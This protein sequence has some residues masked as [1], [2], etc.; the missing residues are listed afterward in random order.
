MCGF[1]VSNKPGV[2]REGLIRQRH[3]GP[4]AVS[5]WKGQGLEMGHVL[6][7]INGSKTIQP[8]VTKKGNVL[9][10]NGE[11]YNCP[12]ENDTAWLGEGMDRYGIRFLEYNNW[13]GAV[14]YLDREKNELL[15]TR[16][17]F[18]A[19][20]LWFQMLSPT[21]WLFSTSLRSMVHKKVDEKYKSSFLFNFKAKANP[22]S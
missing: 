21:E 7:D 19:K 10:F 14:A 15:V 12:I 11:M 9:V 22:A 18:G 8:Y 17:H 13:H 5:M 2:V 20:P 6:L 16:D 3:R 4:D 1:V